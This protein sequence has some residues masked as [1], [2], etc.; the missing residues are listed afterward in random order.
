MGEGSGRGGEGRKWMHWVIRRLRGDCLGGGA[1]RREQPAPRK[2][3]LL[4]MAGT[5]YPTSKL[6]SEGERVGEE[7]EGEGMQAGEKKGRVDRERR[8]GGGCMKHC[9]SH[10]MGVFR[11]CFHACL[12][13]GFLSG[14]LYTMCSWTW[15]DMSLSLS[16]QYHICCTPLSSTWSCCCCCCRSD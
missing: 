12:Y 10:F 11:A 8:G 4:S 2:G 16:A 7:A 3:R 15:R 14:S 9:F 6:S 1:G 13:S 5:M